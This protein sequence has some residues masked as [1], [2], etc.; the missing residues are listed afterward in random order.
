MKYIIWI[1]ISAA[2]LGKSLD[3]GGSTLG[4]ISMSSLLIAFIMGFLELCGAI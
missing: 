1:L 3:S 4:L 2:F